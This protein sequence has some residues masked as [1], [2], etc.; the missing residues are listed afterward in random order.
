MCCG[1][2]T[3]SVRIP[4]PIPIPILSLVSVGGSVA[5]RRKKKPVVQWNDCGIMQWLIK[6]NLILQAAE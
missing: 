6:L 4:V 2:V 5:I 3:I 1:R